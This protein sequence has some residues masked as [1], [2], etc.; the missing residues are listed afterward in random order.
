MQCA[1]TILL[2]VVCP[3]LQYFSPL[4]HKR[5]RIRENVVEH[6]MCV[7]ILSTPLSETFLILRK[8]ERDMIKEIH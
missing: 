3:A 1:C 7:S 2:F 6:K 5:G 8:T 4:S